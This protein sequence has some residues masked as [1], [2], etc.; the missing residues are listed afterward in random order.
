MD[1]EMTEVRSAIDFMD[2]FVSTPKAGRLREIAYAA[3][4][5]WG[6]DP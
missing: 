3:K 4:A 6:Y 2:G 1:A 5:H